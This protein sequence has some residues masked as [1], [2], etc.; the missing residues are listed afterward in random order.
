M[1]KI[2]KELHKNGKVK[3][4]F[5]NTISKHK[6]K[7]RKRKVFKVLQANTEKYKNS[8]IPYMTKLLNK[9]CEIKNLFMDAES[10]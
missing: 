9:E 6:M 5:T 4:L 10:V 2:C 3:N 7:K 1:F 8:A